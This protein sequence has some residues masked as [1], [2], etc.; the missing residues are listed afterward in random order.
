MIVVDV[1]TTGTSPI[2]HSLL[3]IG[4]ID[5][6]KPENTF[7]GECQIWTGAHVADEALNVNGFSKKQI[8]DQSKKTEEQLVRDFLAWVEES[9]DHTIAGQN[10]FFD[11][12]FLVAAAER[13]GICYSLPRRIVDLHSITLFHMVRRGLTNPIKNKR[14]DLSS[15]VIMKYV[16]IPA[17]PHPHKAINGAVWEAEA[18]QRLFYDKS[19]LSDFKMY[20]IPWLC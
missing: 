16:G 19:L 12:E 4:A 2:R 1:E 7:Y 9:D 14:T 10:P 5:F 8:I 20:P 17:E 6:N 18:F 15:G 11:Y 13:A 3:S